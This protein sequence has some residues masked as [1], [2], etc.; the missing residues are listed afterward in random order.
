MYED[1]FVLGIRGVYKDRRYSFADRGKNCS[2]K[3]LSAFINKSGGPILQVKS[4]QSSTKTLFNLLESFLCK[5]DALKD[6][7]NQNKHTQSKKGPVATL[8]H[9]IP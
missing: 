3:W 6:G 4:K 7:V 9:V 2:A 8:V 5:V 1:P